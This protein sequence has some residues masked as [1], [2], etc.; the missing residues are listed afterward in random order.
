MCLISEEKLDIN[1][2]FNIKFDFGKD[3]NHPADWV[4]LNKNSILLPL[5]SP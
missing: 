2:A 1:W 5:D 3:K 4:R